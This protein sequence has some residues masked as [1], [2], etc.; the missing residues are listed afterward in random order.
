MRTIIDFFPWIEMM[1]T[2][3]EIETIKT[4]YGIIYVSRN[5]ISF[6]DCWRDKGGGALFQ[7]NATVQRLLA[8]SRYFSDNDL[9]V[10]NNTEFATAMHRYTEPDATVVSTPYPCTE[11]VYFQLSTTQEMYHKNCP[12]E[13]EMFDEIVKFCDTIKQG[14]NVMMTHASNFLALSDNEYEIYSQALRNYVD[15]N[16]SGTN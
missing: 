12:I 13:F 6:R 3:D 1:R 2:F 11:E 5:T 4:E 9:F 7:S 15:E 8:V 16:C 10:L 14:K